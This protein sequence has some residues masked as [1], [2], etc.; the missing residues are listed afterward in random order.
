MTKY[1]TK[2]KVIVPWSHL[3]KLNPTKPFNN[4]ILEEILSQKVMSDEFWQIRKSSGLFNYYYIVSILHSFNLAFIMEIIWVI[5]QS[6][7]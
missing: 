4:K 6:N 7:V 3:K 5:M 2:T 1:K